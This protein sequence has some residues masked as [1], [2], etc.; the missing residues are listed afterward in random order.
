MPVCIWRAIHHCVF[1]SAAGAFCIP[2]ISDVFLMRNNQQKAGSRAERETH[3]DTA[4]WFL[5]AICIYFY[6]LKLF[7]RTSDKTI[8]QHSEFIKLARR[9]DYNWLCISRHRANNM[10]GAVFIYSVCFSHKTI[11]LATYLHNELLAAAT[12]LH[13]ST[14]SPAKWLSRQQLKAGVW[15]FELSCTGENCPAIMSPLCVIRLCAYRP[16]RVISSAG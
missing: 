4:A 12:L 13:K 11:K 6:N 16:H 9:C 5:K 1:V 10:T 3:S 15:W 8:K 7:F 14:N 2:A